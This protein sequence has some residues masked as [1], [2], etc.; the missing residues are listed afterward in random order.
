[1][2]GEPSWLT[3]KRLAAWSI[4]EKNPL[5][6]VPGV[7]LDE[8]QA[9]VEAPREPIPSHR[10]PRDLQHA[11]DERGDEEGLIIQRDSTLLSR[12]ITKDSSKRGVIFSDL[13]S[14]V[15][16][17]P[18][19]VQRY[20]GSLIKETDP[21]SALNA[22]LWCEG[23]FLFVPAHV[24]IHLPFHDCYWM[25]SPSM[26]IFSRTLAIAEAGSLVAFMDEF[27]SGETSGLSVHMTE[28][29][30]REKARLRHF[31]L[32]NWG[33][34]IHHHARRA[35]QV[36]PSGNLIS[37]DIAMGAQQKQVSMQLERIKDGTQA[38]TE[39][40]QGP[41]PNSPLDQEDAYQAVR[42][43]FAPVLDLIPSEAIRE[44]LSNYAVG[45]VTGH[46]R[47][48]TL[49]RASELLPEIRA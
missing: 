4:Y 7:N 26:G 46:R 1:M 23:A 41:L 40:V 31:V 38:V 28:L 15:K 12:S 34:K 24:E 47:M 44:R 37:L 19:L 2:K 18:E 20:L 22:A 43:S 14:A 36:S 9:W 8:I 16:T 29:V 21:W 3:E 17:V 11:L 25:S 49:Q 27:I 5:P 6:L 48:M 45:K 39:A 10:W 42:T 30:C 13:A 32:Q 35:S 33:A